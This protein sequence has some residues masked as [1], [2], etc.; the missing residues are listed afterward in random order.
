[1]NSKKIPRKY[2]EDEEACLLKILREVQN[3]LSQIDDQKEAPTMEIAY[4]C[5]K[6]KFVN[7]TA[8]G[9]IC[10]RQNNFLIASKILIRP[11]LE[12]TLSAIAVIKQ[13]GILFR[14]L[15]SEMMEEKRFYSEAEFQKMWEEFQEVTLK[16]APDYPIELKRIRIEEIAK[17]A[18]EEGTYQTA[19][20]LYCNFSHGTMRAGG[21]RHLFTDSSDT[22]IF[23]WCV[24][25]LLEE[26]RKL[27]CPETPDLSDFRKRLLSFWKEEIDAIEES[28]S[29]K[30]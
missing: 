24:L 9:Y 29:L 12:A 13:R 17:I 30:R 7:R 19:Y 28:Q 25:F 22:T 2:S 21:D 26:F 27:G 3:I 18:G 6:A 23:A 1:M 16:I 14:K 20:K 4:L 15:Y 10:L 5:E 11:A 8:L